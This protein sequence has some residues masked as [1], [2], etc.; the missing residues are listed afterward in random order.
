MN[1]V[2]NVKI[3]PEPITLDKERNIIF[4]MLGFIELGNEYGSMEDALKALE[5][6]GAKDICNMLWAGLVEE[7]ETLTIRDVMKMVNFHN[8]EMVSQKLNI[9]ME[10]AFPAEV[11][12]Q[13][14]EKIKNLQ[15]QTNPEVK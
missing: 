13:A 10:R 15:S 8:L 5:K 1:D 4:N 14:E 2:S 7:D 3:V 6:G 12:K 11:K 9:A